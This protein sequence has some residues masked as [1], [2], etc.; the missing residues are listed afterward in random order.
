MIERATYGQVVVD[1]Q[2]EQGQERRQVNGDYQALAGKSLTAADRC[3]GLA[4]KCLIVTVH[5]TALLALFGLAVD[6]YL[7]IM[8]SPSQLPTFK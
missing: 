8:A 1:G 7:A 4:S 6:H 2:P 3:Q 5:L